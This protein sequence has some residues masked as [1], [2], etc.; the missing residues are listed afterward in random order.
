MLDSKA[1]KY[2]QPIIKKVA[3][4]LIRFKLKATD[5]TMISLVLGLCSAIA[6]YFNINILAVT[7]LW[8]SGFLDAVDGTIARI[9]DSKSKL[10]AFLDIVF[11]RIVEIVILLV[12]ALKTINVNDLRSIIFTLGAIVLSMTVFLLSG[13]L[14]D[15][16]SG[17]SFYY[18]AGLAE[19]TE[20]FIF[21]T[22]VIIFRD[23][24]YN[25]LNVLTIIILI[26]AI[27]RLL[28]TINFLRGEN[29]ENE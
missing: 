3:T 11:D 26:T 29:N 17:K 27:Q 28:E 21:F 24:L 20:G 12:L 6:L 4:I 13:N 8:L 1:R 10:G 23:Y 22:G 14:L 16:K 7:L 25:I 2:V 19:R 5:V 15:N 9:T 18:Q